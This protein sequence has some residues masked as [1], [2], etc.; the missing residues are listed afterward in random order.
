LIVVVIANLPT[1]KKTIIYF[2]NSAIAEVSLQRA[3]TSAPL[4]AKRVV[5]AIKKRVLATSR[6][7]A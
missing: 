6:S 2:V 7:A 3:L 5:K 1:D 4:R